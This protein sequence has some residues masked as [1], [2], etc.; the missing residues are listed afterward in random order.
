MLRLSDRKASSR[1]SRRLLVEGFVNFV[2]NL[3]ELN[4]FSFV[5]NAVWVDDATD[6]DD[7]FGIWLALNVAGFKL[8]II[9]YTF[10]F[11]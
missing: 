1:V 5:W 8:T 4:Y 6:G 10:N 11:N 7:N 3:G 2:L 9:F